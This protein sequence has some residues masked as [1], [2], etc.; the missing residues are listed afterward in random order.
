VMEKIIVRI[1]YLS[2]WGVFCLCIFKEEFEGTKGVIKICKSKKNRQ[3]NGEKKKTKEQKDKQ[4]STK[5][6]HG[7]K[8]RVTQTLLKRRVNSTLL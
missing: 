3:H 1:D 5:H 2:W 8:D 4:Q 7:I 6:T